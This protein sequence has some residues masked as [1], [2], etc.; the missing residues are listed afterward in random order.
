MDTFKKT[1]SKVF[2]APQI[3][4]DLRA[5]CA[6]EINRINQTRLKY[7]IPP[8]A[9]A[10]VGILAVYVYNVATNGLNALILAYIVTDALYLIF[11]TGFIF[12]GEGVKTNMRSG[13]THCST[14]SSSSR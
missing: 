6:H 3:P 7:L 8:V 12:F 14:S 9:V 10:L 4:E 11:L 5:H 2:S 1:L 13:L